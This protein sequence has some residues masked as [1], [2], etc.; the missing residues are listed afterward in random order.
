MIESFSAYCKNQKLRL[1]PPRQATLDIIRKS[2]KPIGAYDIIH[3]IGAKPT[4]VYR[5]L[6]FLQA[7]GFVHKIESLNS[8]IACGTDHQHHG[9]QF[10]ICSQCGEVT[11]IH[12][13]DMP[14]ELQSKITQSGFKT[15]HW[16]TEIH[17][18][19]V[20]CV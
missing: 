16:N 20:K 1:T 13:C 9:S 17:G 3:A 2:S 18:V 4:T 14:H 5:A 7:H 10:M 15:H 11:E 12:L 19:C 8:F 6:E